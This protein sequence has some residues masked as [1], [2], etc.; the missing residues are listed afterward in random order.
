M[1]KIDTSS[2][3]IL[4][5]RYRNFMLLLYPEWDNYNDILQD[6]KGSFK[7]YAYIEHFPESDEKK[8]HTHFLLCLD[9]PRSIVSLSKRLDV[10][11]NLIQSVK[12]LRASCRYLIHKD[13]DDKNQYELA[14][15]KVSKSFSNTFF[16]SFDDLLSDEE[17]LE[18]IY[19]FISDNKTM[20]KV[21]LEIALTMF[22]SH[23]AFDRVFK[24][25]YQSISKVIN[26][27]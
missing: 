9:N 15:V 12:S 6:L 7:N 24:R 4:E 11:S 27:I 21:D 5:K 2:E 22:V 8:E 20:S 13:N 10:P 3:E 14:N 26:L 1:K 23:N 18:S 17:I 16:K 25:Y 19:N